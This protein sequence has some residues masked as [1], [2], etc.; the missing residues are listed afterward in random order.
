MKKI[1]T[2]VI[3][4]AAACGA[5][6]AEFGDLAAGA[7][8]L[9]AAA[10]APAVPR[11]AMAES[12]LAGIETS[13]RIPYAAVQKAVQRMTASDTNVAVI[14]PAAQ[15]LTRSGEFQ[16]VRN[17][18][19]NVGGVIM[20]PV[21]TLRPYLERTDVLA[22]KVQKVRVH[23]VMTPTPGASG[24][25][26]PVGQQPAAGG[27]G[28]T[29]EQLMSDICAALSKSLLASLDE[30]LGSEPR[31]FKAADILKFSYDKDAWTMRAE[32]SGEF[33]RHYLPPELVGAAH[34]TG[35]SFDDNGIDLKFS[36]Q[37]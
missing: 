9:K 25:Y 5:R 17:L 21:I 20:E 35:F 34:L 4:M 15:L 3:V 36:T 14:D 6:A 23:A 13:I 33:L 10:E 37:R 12:Q 26:A 29:Q 11:P 2:A 27:D 7:A 32:I 1:L 24:S 30:A 31:P 22:V 19:L 16:I 18:R 8:A 28:Y